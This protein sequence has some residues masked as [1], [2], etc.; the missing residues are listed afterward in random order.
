M[1]PGKEPPLPPGWT[2][3]TLGQLLARIEAGK[4]F[5]CDPQVP[6]AGQVGVVK[7]SA[8]TWGTYDE[9]ESK[10]C[11]DPSKVEPA[12]F[13]R[14]GDF[15]FSRANTIALV[16]ACVIAQGTSRTVMLSDKILRFVFIDP[17]L[18]S[19][20][21]W[22][23]R[24]PQGRRQIELLATG[25]QESMRNIGQESIRRI[26][27]PLPPSAERDRIVGE[28]EKH[29]TRLDEAVATLKAV[30]AKLKRARASVLKAAVEGR[31]VPTEAELARAE[32][33]S[34]E[35]ASVL[36]ERILAERR[37]RWPEGKKYQP[38]AEHNVSGQ[39]AL[40][41]GWA[42]ASLSQLIS[43]PLRNGRSAPASPDGSGIRTLTL[44]AITQRRFTDANTK[45]TTAT[46]EE[47]GELWLEPGD[48]LI[49]RSNAPEL[50][51]TVALF[52]GPKHWAVF[53]DLLIRARVCELVRPS[54]VE[55][56]LRSARTR[57][58]FRSRAQG[59]AGSMPK[60]DQ[61]TVE[62]ALVPLPPASEQARIVAEV[63]R[64]LSVIDSLER[65]VEET[66]TR[67][68]RLRQSIL[69]RAFEGKLVPQDPADEPASELLARIRAQHATEAR[70]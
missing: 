10:T 69:K 45:L 9:T 22:S 32:G 70:A 43:E 25:N 11:S 5:T 23:L 47:V 12:Y 55:T 28:I 13:I 26:A 14:P 20:V 36:L 40:P 16:G 54:W 51:G 38:P 49:Q 52:S 4:S 37:A 58:Y 68:G 59:I 19:W 50:V 31:L 48:L 21:L 33:R 64:R 63:E 53:P 46:R 8:V 65:T 60:I 62:R 3:A 17:A 7:V 39:H 29:F 44:T 30:Q 56:V 1:R 18:R 15:L 27:V 41:W 67:C 57:S 66:L 34:Y 61:D 24:S 6:G 42:I 35:P 2:L